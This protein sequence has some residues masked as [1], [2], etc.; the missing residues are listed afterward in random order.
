MAETTD[1][2]PEADVPT[3]AP[4][5]KQNF[6][7]RFAV[8]HPRA[9]KVIAIAGGVTAAGGVLL[10]VNTAKKN[11]AH[12]EAAGDHAKGVLTEISDAVSPDAD[13]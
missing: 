9:A 4:E 1:P 13:V 8:K 5:E 2:T 6:V 11:R 3:D 7:S 12:L 10:T